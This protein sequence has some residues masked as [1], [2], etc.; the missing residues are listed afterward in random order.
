LTEQVDAEIQLILDALKESGLE[1]NT[2]VIF[3]S[4]HGDMNGAHRMEHKT[5]L[6]EESANI[7]FIAMYKGK[8]PAGAVNSNALI[9]NTLD[10]LP[11]VA[12]YAGNPNAKADPRGRSLRPLFEGK[13]TEWRDTLGVE[14]QIGWMVVDNEGKKLIEYDFWRSGTIETQLLDLKA[15]PY[16]TRHFPRTE[17]NAKTWDKLENSLN[18]WF[19][20]EH[21]KNR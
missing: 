16:E 1:E 7:P 8:I 19:P 2:L 9:S 4:D 21:R 14:S 15:D 12:D 5:A 20:E 13:K 6:Y 17:A 10:F 11:T 3:T 18:E